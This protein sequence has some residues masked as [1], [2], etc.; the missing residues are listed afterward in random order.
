[1]ISP[2]GPPRSRADCVRGKWPF[3]RQS[4][5]GPR[6]ALWVWTLA[7][8][9]V[10]PL[11][12]GFKSH[13]ETSPEALEAPVTDADGRAWIEQLFE[14][15]QSWDQLGDELGSFQVWGWKDGEES[16]KCRATPPLRPCTDSLSALPALSINILSDR[17]EIQIEIKD[18]WKL[19]KWKQQIRF[20]KTHNE[21]MKGGIYSFKAIINEGK[22][23]DELNCKLGKLEKG[24][25]SKP[26]ESTRGKNI[27]KTEKLL[28]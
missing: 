21:V 3:F 7:P 24:Q 5:R 14:L 12:K 10:S 28:R 11:C 8:S 2:P 23:I 4:P 22:R 17:R 13:L 15:E 20:C 6:S 1:M 27:I 9:P 16:S 26:N 25:Q 19:M 18:S